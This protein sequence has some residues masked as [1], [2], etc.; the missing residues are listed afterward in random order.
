MGYE[1]VRTS[2]DMNFMSSSSPDTGFMQRTPNIKLLNAVAALDSQI[3]M[4]S[5]PGMLFN[6]LPTLHSFANSDCV[7]A[8][9]QSVSN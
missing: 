2:S 1:A 3:E 8:L 6:L 5:D 9:D 7:T 4:T